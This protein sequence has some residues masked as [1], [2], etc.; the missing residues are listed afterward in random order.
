MA[1]LYEGWGGAKK[2]SLEQFS[3][4]DIRPEN[5]VI[6]SWKPFIHTHHYGFSNS[7]FDS[8]QARHPRRSCE[9]LFAAV[10]N[11]NPYPNHS[12]PCVKTFDELHDFFEPYI[13]A[14]AS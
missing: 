10:M 1:L 7:F 4:I 5:E 11:N 2:R 13:R 14:E 3:V 9:V 8:W 6:G 12:I